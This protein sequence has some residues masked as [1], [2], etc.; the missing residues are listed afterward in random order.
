[1]DIP[2]ASSSEI[3]L[4]TGI[5]IN[6]NFTNLTFAEDE[7]K[8]LSNQVAI[9]DNYIITIT[10]PTNP[11]VFFITMPNSSDRNPN[12]S[13]LITRQYYRKL[14]ILYSLIIFIYISIFGCTLIIIYNR[15]N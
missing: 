13:D 2:T 8:Q 9:Q 14:K 15:E 1:M 4:N 11:P 12:N 10:P 6:D 7:P 3:D 5:I